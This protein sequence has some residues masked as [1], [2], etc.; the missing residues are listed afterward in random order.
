MTF[1]ITFV[2]GI[3]VLM[4]ILFVTEVFALEVTALAVLSIL[5]LSG[6]LSPAEAVS[7]LSNPA[8][9]TIACLFI[10]SRAVQKTGALEYLVV[11]INSL[12]SR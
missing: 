3:I 11:R 12:A 8:V 9:I 6:Y 1:D 7:G 5:F 2:L 10:L 4:F